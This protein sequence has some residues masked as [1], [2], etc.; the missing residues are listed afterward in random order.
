MSNV[1]PPS[2]VEEELDRSP[3]A[4][5]LY[6]HHGGVAS[7]ARVADAVILAITTLT[8]ADMLEGRSVQG[9]RELLV[10]ALGASVV[11]VLHGA[12]GRY[13]LVRYLSETRLPFRNCL[14]SFLLASVSFPAILLLLGFDLS[15]ALRD[16]IFWSGL[17]LPALLLGRQV[18]GRVLTHEGLA[19]RLSRR[20]VVVGEGVTAHRMA[21]SLARDP[22]VR[23]VAKLDGGDP[24]TFGRDLDLVINDFNVRDYVNEGIDAVALAL[25]YERRS[26]ARRILLDLRR[27]HADLFVDPMLV[28]NDPLQPLV[29]IGGC[30]LAI[31]Q[32][33]PLTSAQAF[34][35][36]VFDRCVGL[37]LLLSALPLLLLLM[38]VVRLGSPGPALFRQP[39][40][41]LHGR[42][43]EIL[44]LRTMRT[45]QADLLSDRQTGVDDPRVTREGR[46][47][48][49]LSLDELP[50]LLN[51][52]RGD[53]SLV[54][55]RP[56]APNTR[57]SGKLLDEA[58]AEYVIRHQVKPGITGWAQ[59][60]GARGQLKTIDQLR[61]RVELDLEYMQRWTLLFDIKILILT[62]YREVFSKHAY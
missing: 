5:S 34:Q 27:V 6:I 22:L 51:V 45:D 28:A 19:L 9:L 58:L 39:R 2:A 62:L 29:Q 12:R 4:E 46:W 54:G 16:G 42:R 48:R 50:Q 23:V 14:P 60:N 13:R 1:W 26:E 36:A 38:A 3:V 43:F 32:R 56:H 41:G 21:A 15:L 31:V 20:F 11:F 49:K 47:L 57:A 53:M 25:P 52:V 33:R 10:A 24:S 17:S 30:T 59:V 44:K 37:V 18:A 55:P 7:S 61:R 40:I 8:T 35:K